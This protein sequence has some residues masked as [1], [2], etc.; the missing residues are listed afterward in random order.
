MHSF[1]QSASL[2]ALQPLMQ[3][4]MSKGAHWYPL[5]VGLRTSLVRRRLPPM[6][7]RAG[8]AARPEELLLLFVFVGFLPPFLMIIF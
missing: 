7:P 3:A 4:S 5:F 6:H 2:F 8:V 1:L